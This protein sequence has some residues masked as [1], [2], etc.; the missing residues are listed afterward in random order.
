[1]ESQ[2]VTEPAAEQELRQM[3]QLLEEVTPLN[4]TIVSDDMDRAADLLDRAIGKPAVRYRYPTGKEYGTWI[5]PPSWNVREATLSDGEK[6]LASYQDHVLFVAPYSM[7]FEGWVTRQE[8]LEH[9]FVS[10]AIEEAFAY[11][12]RVA[13]DFQKRLK[14]W[15]LSLPKKLVSGLTKERY[16]VKID[17]DVRPGTLNALEFTAPG[18]EETCVA[19]LAH[20]C[21]PGQANDGLS[22]VVAGAWMIRQLLR[23]PRRFTYKLLVFPE[24]IGS[25]VHVIAQGLSP[26]EIFCALFLETMGKGERLY[27]KKSRTGNQP[28]DLAAKSL[29]RENPD[30]GLLDFYEGYGNDELVF[31]FANVGIPSGSIQHFPFIEYHTSRDAADIIDWGKWRRASELALELFRRLEENRLI[32]LKYPGAPHLTRYQLYADAVTQRDR[33]KKIA[34]LLTLCDGKHTLLQMCEEADLPFEET[35]AFFGKLDR[36]G[37]LL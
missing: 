7:P 27:F 20:L 28:I 35:A 29:I 5:V 14:R 25:T 24:T 21:H 33:F 36:E 4:R 22:G 8:L 10:N 17:V 2:T 18:R 23:K 37:L 32:Q 1:M 3:R 11:Q 6:K 12:H 34:K 9:L 19:F 13:Y 16:Y 31:D 26:K 30:I 15:E